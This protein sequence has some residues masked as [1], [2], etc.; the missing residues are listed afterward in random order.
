[1]SFISINDKEMK[2]TRSCTVL[3]ALTLESLQPLRK[4]LLITYSLLVRITQ[5]SSFTLSRLL[6]LLIKVD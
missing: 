2:S 1:M 4:I 3:V 5:R 6:F